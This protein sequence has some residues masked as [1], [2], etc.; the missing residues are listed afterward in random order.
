MS[1]AGVLSSR[2]QRK[3]LLLASF[4]IILLF[5]A[6]TA[7]F[8]YM[9]P[10]TRGWGI[11][12]DFLVAIVASSVF[13]LLSALYITYFFKDPFE[14]DQARKILPQDIGGSLLSIA[15]NASDYKI[16]VR[17]GR[18]FRAEILPALIR[19]A[20]KS[21]RH[22][23]IEAVLLDI[24]DDSICEKYATYRKVASFDAELWTKEHVQ[25]D[26]Q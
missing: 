3:L 10:E 7:F 15:N 2:Y 23:R 11:I 22:V 25:K 20:K 6:L 16:F 8:W 1:L 9:T 18:H 14:L 19:S 4:L 26:W 13:A 5:L 12:I 17:T 24:R 21:R